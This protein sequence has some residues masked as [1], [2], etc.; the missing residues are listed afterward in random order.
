MLDEARALG[1]TLVELTRPDLPYDGLVNILAAEAAASF[2][3]LTLD[4]QDDLLTWQAPEAW[5]NS[6]RKARFLSAVDHVQFDRLRR[7]VM[8]DME[9][10]FQ[11]VDAIIGP[12]LSGPMMIITNFT[13]HPGLV[14]RCGFRMSPT[15]PR[16]AAA[17][18]TGAVKHTVPHAIS[19]YGRLFD[20]GTLLRIGAAL[21]A[22]L[23]VADRRPPVGV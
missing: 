8:N 14:L 21:E 22:R 7:R 18:E 11:G 3:R 15:R 13:G 10:A 4:D 12:C 19:L 16:G 9:A 5:P 17:A 1:L 23:G 2:E 20:E 6:F